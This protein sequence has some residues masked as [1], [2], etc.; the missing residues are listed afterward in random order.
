MFGGLRVPRSRL[1]YNNAISFVSLSATVVDAAEM[2]RGGSKIYD[3]GRLEKEEVSDRAS[4]T[5]YVR[6]NILLA[7]YLGRY[8]ANLFVPNKRLRTASRERET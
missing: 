5:Y 8:R 4:A 3:Q 1:L 6:F 7:L 2:R